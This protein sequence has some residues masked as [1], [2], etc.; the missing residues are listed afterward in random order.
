MAKAYENLKKFR[1]KYKLSQQDL[2]DF[3]GVTPN[4]IG[5]Y[6]KENEL[7]YLNG[8]Q[9]VKL[10]AEYEN[11][12]LEFF[13]GLTGSIEKDNVE[14]DKQLGLNDLSINKLEKITKS[15]DILQK[16]LSLFALNKIIENVDLA[17]LG[18]YLI[19]PSIKNKSIKYDDNL[20]FLNSQNPNHYLENYLIDENNE[21][22]QNFKTFKYLN[23]V[24]DDIK[25]SDTIINDYNDILKILNDKFDNEQSD[26]YT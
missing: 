6:E 9:L 2:A 18:S 20:K 5:N 24:F 26:I 11:I 14:I 1:K 8:F 22:L 23:N 16:K 10:K 17:K 7:N 3:L 25:K 15:E 13:L 19:T 12:P 4:S 21:N